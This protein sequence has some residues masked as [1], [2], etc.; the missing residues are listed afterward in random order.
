MP[1]K[2]L[3]DPAP[4]VAVVVP[5]YR[6]VEHVLDVLAGI[7]PE[8]AAIIVVDDACPD[9]TGAHVRDNCADP[10]VEVVTHETNTGVGGATITGYR[11]A[12]SSGAEIIV[13]I[14]GDGQMDPALI[15]T[16]IAPIREG[17]ADYVKGNRF[18]DLDGV[19]HMPRERIVGNLVLSFAT[20]MSSGYWDMFDPT[21]GF[22]AVHARVLGRL[23]L[24]KIS[25][26]F[27]FESDMLFRLNVARAVVTEVPMT[28]RYGT[29]TSKLRIRRVLLQFAGKHL[30]NTAKRIFYGYFL[31][32]FNVASIELLVGTLLFWFGVIFGA[33]R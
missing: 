33:V 3:N 32:D 23:P 25:T 24:D 4:A 26:G 30:A 19:S 6:E 18:Y 9:G 22:T 8:V 1:R 7:G 13:K 17:N 21:N 10:R 31:R 5:C 12:T 16:L 29:E 27:F 15:P 11:R 14:D 2:Q 20:K 28:A